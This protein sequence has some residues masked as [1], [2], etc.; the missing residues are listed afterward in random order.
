[1]YCRHPEETKGCR[2]PIGMFEI[3]LHHCK[4][5]TMF[6]GTV[7]FMAVELLC[8]QVWH[9]DAKKVKRHKGNYEPFR[10]SIEQKAYH[11]LE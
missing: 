7:I 10:L 4:A 6:Q 8:N 5:Q 1:M 11:D 9:L 2:A 3:D